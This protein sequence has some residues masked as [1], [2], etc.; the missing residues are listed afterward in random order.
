[1]SGSVQH[2][3][4]VCVCKKRAREREVVMMGVSFE[5]CVVGMGVGKRTSPIPPPF[6]SWELVGAVRENAAHL[7]VALCLPFFMAGPL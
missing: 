5:V 3:V 2:A 6:P 7:V 4:S 1:M